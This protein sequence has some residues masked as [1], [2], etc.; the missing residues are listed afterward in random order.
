[1]RV[2]VVP[3]RRCLVAALGGQGSGG[4]GAM[5]NELLR[6]GEEEK[7]KGDLA[8]MMVSQRNRRAVDA[9]HG[10]GDS[11]RRPVKTMGT[12]HGFGKAVPA[13]SVSG[14]RASVETG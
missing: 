2:S 8:S 4:G 6:D 11:G 1:M 3:D 13:R 5:E 7:A 12:A 9:A 10:R 14:A